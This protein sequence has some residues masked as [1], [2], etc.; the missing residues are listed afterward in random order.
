MTLLVT[1]AAA[2]DVAEAAVWYEARQPGLGEVFV[3]TVDVM[4]EQIHEHPLRCRVVH[5]ALR[6]ALLPRFPY[7]IFYCVD[8]DH[9][10]VLGVLHGSRDPSVWLDRRP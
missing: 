9:L 2:A 6:R 8:H 5:A 3:V 7:S 4:L 10:V 1:D